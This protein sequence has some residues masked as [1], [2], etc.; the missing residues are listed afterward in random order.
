[1]Y[2][3]GFLPGVGLA[4]GAPDAGPLVVVPPR[5]VQLDA[6]DRLRA[7]P[8]GERAWRI[9]A[10]RGHFQSPH[11]SADGEGFRVRE[12]GPGGFR[13]ELTG[14]PGRGDVVLLYDGGGWR[15]LR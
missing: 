10:A 14:D 13:L 1:V 9:S 8:L 11:A 3:N 6:R 15:R 4:G 5:W 7:E 2:R 12:A